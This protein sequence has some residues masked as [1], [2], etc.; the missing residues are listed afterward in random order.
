MTNMISR[1]SE[2]PG[3]ID[4]AGGAHGADTAAVLAEVGVDGEQLERLREAGVV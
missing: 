3:A 2:T 1:L 4:H